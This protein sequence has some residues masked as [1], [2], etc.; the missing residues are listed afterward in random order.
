MQFLPKFCAINLFFIWGLVFPAAALA[1][2]PDLV[3]KTSCF[4]NDRQTYDGFIAFSTV[5]VLT[6][7][8][9]GDGFFAKLLFERKIKN[10]FSEE[11]YQE[12]KQTYDCFNIRYLVDEVEVEGYYLARKDGNGDVKKPLLIFNRGGNGNFGSLSLFGFLETQS[13]FADA[14]YIVLASQYRQQDE[15]GGKDLNDVIK[16]VELGRRLP[17]VDPAR[18]AMFGVSRGGHMTYMAA[19]QQLNLKT[20][21]VWAGMSDLTKTHEERPEMEAVYQYRIPNY[22]TNTQAELEKRSVMFWYQDLPDNMPVLLLHGDKDDRVN[23][24][25]S[26]RL[27]DRLAQA[28]RPHE[29]VIYRDG[30]HGLKPHR[31]AAFNKILAWLKIY[32]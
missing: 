3:S 9:K 16:L 23:V 14:G 30:D 10:R 1:S 17:E 15:F 27:A 11:R 19:R 18:V 7:M 24:A 8:G 28:G 20:I 21:I 2:E 26:R 5:D 13:R 25:Q 29:L 31:E 4:S 12:V 22:Q 32:L 6:R